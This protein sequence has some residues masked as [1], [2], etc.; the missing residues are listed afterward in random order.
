MAEIGKISKI[1]ELLQTNKL[2]AKK[3]YGQNF[4]VDQNILNNIVRLSGITSE[5]K[6]I[7]IGPGLGSLTELLV[8]HSK[9][10][11]AYEIDRDFIP[12]LETQFQDGNFSVIEDDFLKRD[13]DKDIK[14]ILEDE[15]VVVVSN[16]PYYIT[17]PII[18]KILEETKRIKRM[19]FMM[20]LEVA[21]RMTS[22][23]STKDYNA[24]SVI[25]QYKTKAKFGMRIPRTV[26]IPEPNVDSAVIVLDKKDTK[27]RVSNE[28]EFI[29]FVKTAFNQRRKTLVNNIIGLFD[30]TKSELM[31]DLDSLGYSPS[32]RAEKCSVEDFIQL[33][34]YFYEK[35][36][37]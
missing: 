18:F 16:L 25:I 5:T 6:V 31:I 1:K 20:Q 30:T 26:F 19:V 34:E 24:L 2:Q 35:Y 33:Y 4:L 7:E 9:K 22:E 14:D 8:E 12:I 27:G 15:E 11:L 23:P 21:R 29:N 36:I 13:V 32:I 28:E 17:T 3:K 10:V 37:R